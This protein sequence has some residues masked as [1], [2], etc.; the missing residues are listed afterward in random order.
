[1]QVD[2]DKTTLRF[3]RSVDVNWNAIPEDSYLRN[4]PAIRA[5]DSLAFDVP[6]TF[7]VGENGTGKSTLLE[8][9]AT[10]YGFNGEG[11][12]LNYR[13]STYDDVSELGQA[14]S[15][16]RERGKSRS[17]Y[18]FRAESFFNMA[19]AALEYG[20]SPQSTAPNINL[21]ELS[22]GESFL[23]FVD[24][25]E[26]EGLYLMDEPESALSAQRQL[27]LLAMIDERAAHG[28]QFIIATH[29]PILLGLP[30]AT[31]L[32][33]DNPPIRPCSYEETNAYRVTETFINHRESVLRH[34]LGEMGE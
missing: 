21:H 12:T 23:S 6:V 14:L 10:T 31:I 22:H 8:A 28:S 24:A 9:I 29:S 26:S 32:D 33:F 7:L 20:P 4:I 15:I 30:D 27:S 18:F 11:G 25:F 16:A 1:M 3:I 17:S 13:F 34:L 5:L 19:T 2:M